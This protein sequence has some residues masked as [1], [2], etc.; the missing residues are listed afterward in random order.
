[1]RRLCSLHADLEQPGQGLFVLD[2]ARPSALDPSALDPSPWHQQAGGEELADPLDLLVVLGDVTLAELGVGDAGDGV[3]E[4]VLE[5]VRQGEASPA[6]GRPSRRRASEVARLSSTSSHG[7]SSTA[8]ACFAAICPTVRVGGLG[9]ALCATSRHRWTTC[10][11]QNLSLPGDTLPSEHS[12]PRP[13]RARVTRACRAGV[14]GVFLA[15]DAPVTLTRPDASLHRGR[16]GAPS[17]RLVRSEGIT[18][19]KFEIKKNWA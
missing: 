8:D 2:A 7:V 12:R 15:R 9:T 16:G 3:V 19:M 1:M 17:L 6:R 4:D 10:G 18:A 14:A 5:L 11:E 13:R